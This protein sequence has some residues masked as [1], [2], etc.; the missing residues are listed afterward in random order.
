MKALAWD[1]NRTPTQRF[2]RIAGRIA[3]RAFWF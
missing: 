1:G 2:F 3:R